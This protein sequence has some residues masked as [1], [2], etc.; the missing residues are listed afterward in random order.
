[1]PVYL[2]KNLSKLTCNSRI[3][4]EYYV[5]FQHNNLN[6]SVILANEAFIVDGIHESP[7]IEP[8]GVSLLSA[9]AIKDNYFDF[10]NVLTISLRQHH[11]NQRSWLSENDVLI[12][13]VGTIGN[14]AVV[15]KQIV[16]FN[17]D[18]HVGLVRLKKD[19]LLSPYYLATYL[20]SKYGKKQTLSLATGNVQLNLYI[21]KMK[22]L[23]IPLLSILPTVNSITRHSYWLLSKSLAIA[24]KAEQLFYESIEIYKQSTN[25]LKCWT[26]NICQ[27]DAT[28]RLD[29]EF[30]H[31]QH[32]RSSNIKTQTL[33]S[34]VA[35]KKGIEVGSNKYCNEGHKF[36]RV[37]DIT[38]NG[39]EGTD[40]KYISKELYESLKIQFKP[41][42]G[43][44][45]LTKDASPGV[46]TLVEENIDC[47][48]SSGVLRL[49]LT[50]KIN[51]YYLEFVINSQFVKKQIERYCAGSVIIHWKPSQIENTE[52]PRLAEDQ[53]NEIADFVQQS[54]QLR[55]ES[56]RLLEVA[57]T[58][59]EI[60]IEESEERAMQYLNENQPTSIEY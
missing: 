60:A 56:K 49:L 28:H 16:T 29:P 17:I 23:E 13:T 33:R 31:P 37:S 59:V 25:T 24:R 10:N 53:E 55:R 1:M 38:T 6:R 44:I 20:N 19:S 50:E 2:T 22:L 21:E 51:P 39:V 27:I 43:E 35:Y 8:N 26:T 9:K 40:T 5:A 15:Q 48:V 34:I 57:K 54:H 12:T 47:I 46:A 14:A 18:R 11:K 52:I 7:D 4:T 32:A 41:S 58:A 42:V 3:D 45:L 36:I 30:W